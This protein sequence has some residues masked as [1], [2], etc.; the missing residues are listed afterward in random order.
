MRPIA[1]LLLIALMPCA[2]QGE[3]YRWV[4]K[5]GVIH[6]TDEPPS[7]NA[8]PAKLPPL[9][10]ISPIAPATPSRATQAMDDDVPAAPTALGGNQPIF[11]LSP[12]PDQTF[13]SAERTVPVTVSLDGP[14]EKGQGLIFFL[15]DTPQGEGP[16]RELST[17]IIEVER[18]EHRIGAAIVDESGGEIARAPEVTV[19]L[20]PPTVNGPASPKKKKPK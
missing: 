7:K 4:D 16:T 13:R 12:K 18:G 17:T 10:T 14:L 11:I 5:D 2:V 15:D 3:I 9:Q 8:K 1:L 19:H 6:Y 20:K